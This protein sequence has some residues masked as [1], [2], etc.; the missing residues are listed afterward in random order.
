MEANS[1]NGKKNTALVLV[2]TRA[3]KN[4]EGFF[5]HPLSIENGNSPVYYKS[6]STFERRL[7]TRVRES[8]I[9]NTI[10]D[11]TRAYRPLHRTR[12]AILLLELSIVNM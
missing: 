4:G 12:K 2:A 5:L 11:G 6:A 1:F 10:I 9:L 7:I 8:E 3:I